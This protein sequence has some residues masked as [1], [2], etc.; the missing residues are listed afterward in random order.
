[1][2]ALCCAVQVQAFGASGSNSSSNGTS[3][4]GTSHVLVDSSIAGSSNG[5]S[6]GLQSLFKGG[7]FKGAATVSL[8]S[9]DDDRVAADES[10]GQV[11]IPKHWEEQ[12]KTA[13]LGRRRVMRR[14]VVELAGSGGGVGLGVLAKGTDPSPTH[15]CR[16]RP[17]CMGVKWYMGAVYAC[18]QQAVGITTCAQRSSKRAQPA[19]AQ[20]GCRAAGL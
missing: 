9:T 12:I 15:A 13:P 8:S 14:W 5:S 10:A 11:L 20:L 16:Y 7:L 19:S 17:A 2:L 3:S 18:A 6:A 4:N 1:M